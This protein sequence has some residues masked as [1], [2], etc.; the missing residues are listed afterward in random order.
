MSACADEHLRAHELPTAVLKPRDKHVP[1]L[2]HEMV[3]QI[4]RDVYVR[5]V[6]EVEARTPAK[7]QFALKK[8]RLA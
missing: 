7:T 2:N 8:C 6:R 3:V 4:V 1:P 5:A